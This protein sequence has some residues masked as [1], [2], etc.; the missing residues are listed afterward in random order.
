MKNDQM[1]DFRE[2][3]GTESSDLTLNMIMRQI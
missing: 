3:N 1:I 2:I